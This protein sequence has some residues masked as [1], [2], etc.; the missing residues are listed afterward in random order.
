MN[1]FS[2]FPTNVSEVTNIVANLKNTL[3]FLFDNMPV[4][5]L[6]FSMFSIAEHLAAVINN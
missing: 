1:S 6:I 5:I 4:S 2:F 3:S